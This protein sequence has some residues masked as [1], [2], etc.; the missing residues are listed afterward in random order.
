MNQVLVG[1]C[2]NIYLKQKNTIEGQF[3]LL[4]KWHVVHGRKNVNWKAFMRCE[5]GDHICENCKRNYEW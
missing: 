4:N 3:F 5:R 2:Y 1:P